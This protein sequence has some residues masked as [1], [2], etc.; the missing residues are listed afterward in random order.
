MNTFAVIELLTRAEKVSSYSS[1][2]E[3]N[4]AVLFKSKTDEPGSS[5]P[6][7]KGRASDGVTEWLSSPKLCTAIFSK[8]LIHISQLTSYPH[9]K[10]A[11]A[12]ISTNFK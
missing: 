1:T 5:V 2:N 7:G 9:L 3:D 11:S 6:S 4:S 10:S 8:Q 12:S